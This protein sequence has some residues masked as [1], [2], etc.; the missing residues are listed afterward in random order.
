MPSTSSS[1][2]TLLYDFRLSDLYSYLS[3]TSWQQ[4]LNFISIHDR[5]SS[6]G[7]GQLLHALLLTRLLPHPKASLK[8]VSSRPISNHVPII[9]AQVRISTMNHLTLLHPIFIHSSVHIAATSYRPSFYLNFTGAT[10]SQPTTR[11]LLRTTPQKSFVPLLHA[12]SVLQRQLI[13]PP[14]TLRATGS[15][16][17]SDRPPCSIAPHPPSSGATPPDIFGCTARY[18]NRPNTRSLPPVFYHYLLL[19]TSHPLDS[20]G[21]TKRCRTVTTC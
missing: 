12:N 11:A 9:C 20:T 3:S 14:L 2:C 5:R 8:C 7:V 15:D 17:T 19:L 18:R 6:C 16:R 1:P 4:A 21:C 10:S 13:G